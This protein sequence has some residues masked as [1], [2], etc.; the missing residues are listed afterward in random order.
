MSLV[1]P[2]QD[3][4][5]ATPGLSGWRPQLVPPR[6][7]S[8]VLA[9]FI[10]STNPYFQGLVDTLGRPDYAVPPPVS[11]VPAPPLLPSN[12][13]DTFSGLLA[14]AHSSSNAVLLGHSV[15]WQ[16]LEGRR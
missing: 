6:L 13:E 15:A 10:I 7:A 5:T 3:G 12:D 14:D 8:A 2:G 1:P 11:P 16:G 4:V 9:G